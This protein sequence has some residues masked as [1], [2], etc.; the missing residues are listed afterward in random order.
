MIDPARRARLEVGAALA[1]A[2]AA[3]WRRAAG[4]EALAGEL[5]A[6]VGEAA[7]AARCDVPAG[8]ARLPEVP[9]GA[10][11]DEAWKLIPAQYRTVLEEFGVAVRIEASRDALTQSIGFYDLYGK[12]IVVTAEGMSRNGVSVLFHEA[13]HA[14]DHALLG[15]AASP[16][17]WFWSSSKAF[18]AAVKED[19]K[20]LAAT[21][22]GKEYRAVLRL[23]SGGGPSA[24]NTEVFADLFATLRY[25][26]QVRGGGFAMADFEAMFPRA[27]AMVKAIE[28]GGGRG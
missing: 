16:G 27:S 17:H 8:V 7:N 3:A 24:V 21:A 18:A 9:S 10:T 2:A 28:V 12:Q 6:I 25:G 20:L 19:M 1:V 26:Q 14:M 4:S 22:R 5:T 15:E 23:Y 13:G 11:V